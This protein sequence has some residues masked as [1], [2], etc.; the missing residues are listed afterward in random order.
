MR[1]LP[2]LLA[3]LAVGLWLVVMVG[4]YWLME[5]LPVAGLFALAGYY[6]IAS[7]RSARGSRP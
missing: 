5:I 4:M 1:V 2:A 6:A 7:S 3:V